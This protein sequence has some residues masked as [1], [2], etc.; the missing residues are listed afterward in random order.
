VAPL[1]VPNCL[2][3]V[4]QPEKPMDTAKATAVG[5]RNLLF[6]MNICMCFPG[7]TVAVPQKNPL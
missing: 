2:S 6:G 4:A 7:V 1:D 5:R 3:I